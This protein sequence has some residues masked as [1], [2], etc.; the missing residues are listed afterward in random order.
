MKK[1][2]TLRELQL[3]ETYI[4]NDLYCK[5]R[6]LNLN[7][8]LLGGTLIGAVRH[9]GFVPWD[10]DIDV[11][12]SRTDYKVLLEKTGGLISDKCSIID[13]ESNLDF[14]GYIPLCVYNDSVLRSGQFRGNEQ[15][16]LSISI[17]IYDGAPS[18]RIA[19]FFYYKKMYLLRAKHALCRANFKNVNTKA[20]KVFGPILSPFF[21]EKRVYL[22][23]KRILKNQQKYQY[24][25]STLVCTNADN[26]SKKEVATKEQFEKSIPLTFEGIPVLAFSHYKEHLTKYY[27][28]YMSLPPEK[29][30][31][32][33]HTFDVE[34]NDSF[35]Y[36]WQ[37]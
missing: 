21:N 5:C 27:G 36:N 35:D 37:K 25:Q 24:S 33:K 34:I 3:A 14:K 11:C 20:A 31:I 4:L 23:K 8:Y 12:M 29:E 15:L 6:E 32:Q 10:D 30:Q 9:K 17:F 18:S 19:R 2:K 26:N 28:D 1:I 16:K 22:Y 7:L 13:P